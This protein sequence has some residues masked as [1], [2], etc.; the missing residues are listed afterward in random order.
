MPQ[1]RALVTI[2]GCRDPKQVFEAYGTHTAAHQEFLFHGLHH[3]NQVVGQNVFFED[4]F[5]LS[6]HFD[7]SSGLLL[8]NFVTKRSL[9]LLIN[10]KNISIIRGEEIN[11]CQSGKW[12]RQQ[13]RILLETGGLQI[14]EEWQHEDEDYG[15]FNLSHY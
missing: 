9:D 5:G 2:D 7:E 1:A 14:L 4:D 11:I 13:V 3:A 12:P 6:T 10:G 8:Q 15:E